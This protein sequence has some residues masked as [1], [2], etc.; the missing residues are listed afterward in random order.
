MIKITFIGAG[1]TV[2]AKN[3]LGDVL[4]TPEISDCD[5]ALYDIDAARL[6]ESRHIIAGINQRYNKGKAKVSTYC[7]PE[8]RRAALQGADFIVV[9]I[10]VGGYDPCTKIDFEIP[11]RF[12][13]RQT[14]GD[15]MGVGGIFRAL[16]TLPVFDE[17]MQDVVDCAPDALFINYVNPM[18]I[19][20]GYLQ[21]FW[22][23]KTIGLCHSV[24]T[25]SRELLKN[26]GME[27][28]LEGR[29]DVVAGIN[30]MAWLLE[31]HDR[32]GNDLY[33]EIRRRALEK[34]SDP[35]CKDKV[36]FEYIRRLGY[37]CTES[38]EH[39]AE[40]NAFFI[41]K[42]YPEL[43]ERYNIPLDEYLRRCEEQIAKWS[44]T[45]KL[46]NNGGEIEHNRSEEYA[47]R[48]IKAVATNTPF[49][50]GANV[51]NN[52]LIENL[53]P[54]ACVEVPCLVDGKGVLPCRVGPLPL[55][56]AAMNMSNIM[57]QLL[58]IEA[59][60]SRKKEDIYHAVMMDPHAASELSLDEIVA[61]CDAL[62]E[63]HGN[64]L[65]R[66]S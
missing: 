21:R 4:L 35:S 63:A 20:T 37:Y 26:L 33:P 14:I 2:F 60:R 57:P 66:F 9:A 61:M 44:E 64:W 23:V 22:P 39:N 46:L 43:I 53:P 50:M 34:L 48:L 6:E 59:Y 56:L 7:G 65:P 13:L 18:A 41:K 38:S 17:I 10:Q 32:D 40:Y 45:A 19:L 52:G 3:V 27:D 58:A 16:R 5:I 29:V 47:P 49:T 24:Q 54:Q 28:K 15:T 12:G 8:N 36:R 30:H 1:S 11:K 42:Q 51:L 25:C 31:I 55:Q 62:I